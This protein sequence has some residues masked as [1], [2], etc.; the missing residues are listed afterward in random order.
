M[1][2]EKENKVIS[3]FTF[4]TNTEDSG[5]KSIYHKPGG[6]DV[7]AAWSTDKGTMERKLLVSVVLPDGEVSDIHEYAPKKLTSYKS[8]M[9]L[10]DMMGIDG[11]VDVQKV[12]EALK[13]YKDIL[14]TIE[15]GSG[16][17]SVRQ[18]HRLLTEQVIKYMEPGK[19]F[20][21]DGYGNIEYTY[22]PRLLD[23][24]GLGYSRLE[25]AKNFR[26]WGLIRCNNGTG[27]LNSF[28]IKSKWYFSF[29]LADLDS[30]EGGEQA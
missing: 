10:A 17:C 30:E 15:M 21:Q 23:K 1:C 24:L 11:V 13:E 6:I 3:P 18:A 12:Y 14:N 9:D 7:V 8:M 22:L 27:H 25:L 26:F 29:K 20:I 28:K 19:V 2:I 16:K 5:L 4:T